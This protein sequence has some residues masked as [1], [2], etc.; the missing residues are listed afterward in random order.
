M[1]YR[2]FRMYQIIYLI[3]RTIPKLSVGCTPHCCSRKVNFFCSIVG[4]SSSSRSAT[5]SGMEHR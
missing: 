3:P 1:Q 4:N 5:G 2:F